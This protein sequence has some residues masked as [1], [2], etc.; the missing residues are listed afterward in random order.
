M[1]FHRTPLV[2]LAGTVVGRLDIED[3]CTSAFD[4]SD[5]LRFERLAGALVGLFR[6]TR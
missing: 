5:L 2:L 3:P 6:C 1:A 4:E